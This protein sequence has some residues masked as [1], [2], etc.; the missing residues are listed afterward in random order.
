VID[1]DE[2]VPKLPRGRGFK[3]STPEI[4]KILI[5]AALL[6]AVIVLARPCGSAV[7]SFMMKFDNG[8]AKGSAARE[9]PKPDTVKPPEHYE[10]ITPNMT[11]EEKKAAY[12]REKARARGS[13]SP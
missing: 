10:L 5:T 4:F 11:D 3:L 2:P 1:S 8:S 7:S 12:E 13:Q 9:M 6:V